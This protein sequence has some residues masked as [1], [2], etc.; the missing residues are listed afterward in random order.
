MPL[1]TFN[2]NWLDH[3]SQRAYPLFEE[4]SRTDTSG[5][6]KIP[7]DLILAL[8][9]PVHSGLDVD[10]AKFFVRSI[11]IFSAGMSISIGY[12][13]GTSS[14]PIVATSVIAFSTHTEYHSYALPGV[15]DFDDSSGKIVI[16]SPSVFDTLP[17]GQFLFSPDAGRLDTD[18]IRLMLR[19]LS[20]VVLVNGGERSSRLRGDLELTA[21]ANI[22]L[23]PISSG[24]GTQIRIDAIDGAGLNDDCLCT[25]DVAAIPVKTIN[26][27]APSPAGNFTFLGN[28]CITVSAI[29]NGVKFVDDCSAPCCGCE[30]LEAVTRDL[31]K[32]GSAATTLENVLNRLEAQSNTMAMTVLGSKLGDRGC[33]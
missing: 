9:F 28:D 21:G 1:S 15:D 17:S 6:F 22:L 27:I 14:P 3:N 12:D 4:A 25:G 19:G 31:G 32:F 8:Y 5:S 18:C 23:T 24:G 13:D 29:G 11:G 30:E 20:S 2:L 33:V 16:G 7:D 10:P 26:G